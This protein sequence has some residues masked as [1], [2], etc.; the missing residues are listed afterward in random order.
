MIFKDISIIFFLKPIHIILLAI[1]VNNV[2][3]SNKNNRDLNKMYTIYT[4][5]LF[6][7]L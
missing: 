5:L 3:C 4:Y 2:K 6:L 1:A 7:L